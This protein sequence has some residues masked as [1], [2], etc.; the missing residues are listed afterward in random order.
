[1]ACVIRHRGWH[2]SCCDSVSM[3]CVHKQH[4]MACVI[5][6]WC[7]V[8]VSQVS[9]LLQQCG[10]SQPCYVP[11]VQSALVVCALEEVTFVICENSTSVL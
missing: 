8:C 6:H 4:G 2:C 3:T 5:M 1:M 10:T 7:T 9:S 11:E